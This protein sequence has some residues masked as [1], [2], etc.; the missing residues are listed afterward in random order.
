MIEII[1]IA[2]QKYTQDQYNKNKEVNLHS[3]MKKK[4]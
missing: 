4:I 3:K 2:K 1:E